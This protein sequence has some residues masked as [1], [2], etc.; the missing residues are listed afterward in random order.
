MESRIRTSFEK[1]EFMSTLG[2]E[3]VSIKKGEVR[4]DCNFHKGLS[5]Q[6]GFFHAGVVT[7]IVDSACGYAAL[8][9][10][11][12]NA[13]VLSV[14]FKVNL[15]RPCTGSKIIAIGKV[16]KSGKT[17]SVCEGTVWD[18]KEEKIL[19]KMIATMICIESD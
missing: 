1:Q 15:L 2:A 10:M 6:D 12:E 16:I 9:I 14:E 7:S 8:S 17:L 19:A 18:E 5:Q 13:R 3:L 11:P 4:I